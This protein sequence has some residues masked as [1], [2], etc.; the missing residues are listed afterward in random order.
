MT[1]ISVNSETHCFCKLQIAIREQ[2][3]HFLFQWFG[4]VV[5]INLSPYPMWF[6]ILS[7]V[8]DILDVI[9]VKNT[10]CI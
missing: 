1:Q 6:F 2:V 10:K 4:E 5:S 7:C 9:R 3:V 8:N